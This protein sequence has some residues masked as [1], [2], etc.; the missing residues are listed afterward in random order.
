VHPLPKRASA[1]SVFQDVLVRDLATNPTARAR[2]FSLGF[3]ELGVQDTVL[4]S[5]DQ[6]RKLMAQSEDLLP[7]LRVRKT[8]EKQ[9]KKS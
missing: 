5:R 2:S 8:N 4:P 1:S 9:N 6:I 7:E 3:S